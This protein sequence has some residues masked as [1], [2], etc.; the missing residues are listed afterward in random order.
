MKSVVAAAAAILVCLFGNLG[1]I[2]L[3]GPDEPRYAWVARAMAT[4]GDWVT[5]RLF[6]SPWFEKPVL[7]YWAAAIGF[8]LHLPPEWAARLPSAISALAVALVLGWLA[9]KF[10]G[11]HGGVEAKAVLLA[12]ILFS[13]SVAAIGFARAATPDMLFCSLLTL[14]MASAAAVLDRAGVFPVGGDVTSSEKQSDS[15]PLILFGASLGL[16]VLAKGPAALILAGGALGAWAL[17]TRHLRIAIRLLHPIVIASFSV[18]ALPWYILCALRNP[19]FIHVFI[20][21]HNFERYLTPLFQ[22]KQPLW[23]FG[24]IVFLAL[25][26]WT[27]LL[28]PVTQGALRRWRGKS[29]TDSAGFFFA[30]WAIFP[31]LFFS[32]SQSKLPGYILPAVP[33]L[34]LLCAVGAL[35]ASKMSRATT[36]VVAAGISAVWIGLALIGFHFASRLPH[37]LLDQTAMLRVAWLFAFGAIA[38]AIV[39]AL[40]GARGKFERLI[41]VCSVCV[42][43][44]VELANLRILPILDRVHSARSY[45][46]SVRYDRRPDRIFTWNLNR[47]WDYGLAFYFGRELPQWSPAD[48]EPALVLTTREGLHEMEKLGRCDG[49]Q[50]EV[51]GEV[52]FVPVRPAP[53]RN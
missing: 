15:V 35:S 34:V 21:E 39:S 3:V 49:S 44:T 45:A 11:E 13:T 32:F 36:I 10:Y 9:R 52:L 14:A 20:F 28:I 18:V 51:L 4:T 48:N 37:S 40:W 7:F 8:R 43:L 5:P 12:P 53:H 25:L 2:G 41:V 24:P 29:W 42:A 6:G 46:E 38:F 26:P 47:N 27:V 17:L 30:C 33:P 19:D 22:H 31:L 23:F 1:A 16:G 50:D